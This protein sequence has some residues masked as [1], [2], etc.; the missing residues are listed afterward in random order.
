[1]VIVYM[2]ISVIHVCSISLQH[3]YFRSDYL[4]VNL[5]SLHTIKLWI[6]IATCYLPFRIPLSFPMSLLVEHTGHRTLASLH[7]RIPALT[8]K[9]MRLCVPIA[10]LVE[11]DIISNIK[12]K[13]LIPKNTHTDK[14]H[15]FNCN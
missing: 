3:Y 11:H 6:R 7:C 10:Q 5:L 4:K 15:T 1:M 14:Q 12:V 8:S 2:I 9:L 13:S